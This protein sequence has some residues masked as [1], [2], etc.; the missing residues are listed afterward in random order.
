MSI[1]FSMNICI[2]IFFPPHNDWRACRYYISVIVQM[3][4]FALFCLLYM[5]I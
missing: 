5:Y 1:V 2:H 3:I 4:K